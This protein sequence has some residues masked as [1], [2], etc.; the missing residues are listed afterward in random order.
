MLPEKFRLDLFDSLSIKTMRYVTA[1]KNKEATGLAVA[2]GLKRK[3]NG[4]PVK[5]RT[6]H[7]LH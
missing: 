4:F 5:I 3:S 1:V 7:V 6:L 2:A